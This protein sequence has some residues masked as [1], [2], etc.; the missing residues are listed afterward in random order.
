[1]LACPRRPRKSPNVSVK[2]EG[3]QRGGVLW[4]DRGRHGRLI[5]GPCEMNCSLYMPAWNFNLELINIYSLPCSVAMMFIYF[6]AGCVDE[7]PLLKRQETSTLLHFP[8]LC[9]DRASAFLHGRFL[10]SCQARIYARF[11]FTNLV[12]QFVH[13]TS[14]LLQARN[15]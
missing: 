12:L 15:T 6:L 8:H 9:V 10:L 11:R 13:H 14:A 1:M 3:R 5:I 2:T 7:G 4:H